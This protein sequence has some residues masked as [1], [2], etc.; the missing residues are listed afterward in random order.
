GRAG[1]RWPRGPRR[2]SGRTTWSTPTTRSWTT[3]RTKGVDFRQQPSNEKRDD[4]MSVRTRDWLK[5]GTLV[6]IA[7]IFGLAFASAL[8]LPKQ[9]SAAAS[10]VSPQPAAAV[11]ATPI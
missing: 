6:A 4:E 2:S 9:T 5:F 7:F 10:I 3:K 1:G 8:N 11:A